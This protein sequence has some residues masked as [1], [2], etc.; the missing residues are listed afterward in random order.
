M[1]AANHSRQRRRRM[2]LARCQAVADTPQNMK[3]LKL[4]LICITNCTTSKKPTKIWTTDFL[5]FKP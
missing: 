3:L 4:T 2:P 5:M 1:A